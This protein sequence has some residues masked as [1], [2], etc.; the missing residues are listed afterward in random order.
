MMRV[1]TL[2]GLAVLLVAPAARA[3]NVTTEATTSAVLIREAGATI[4]Q[5][6]TVTIGLRRGVAEVDGVS[7]VHPVDALSTPEVT[8][9]VRFA[10]DELEPIA[11]MVRTGDARA[12]YERADEI[13]EI[14]EN[15][16]AAVRR[17][18]LVDAYMLAAV[19]RCQA[20]QRRVC[21]SRIGD[22]VA[23]R[24]SLRYDPERYGPASEEVFDRARARALSGARG[25]L[26]VE[27]EPAG[28]EVYIDGRSYGPSPVTAEGLLAGQH[29]VTVKELGYEKL[30]AR[31]DVRAGRANESTF[32]LEPNAR[33][34]LVISAD[35]QAAIRGEL[36]AER[37]GAAIRSL[38]NTLGTTQVIVGVLRPAAG[39]QV[40][41][42]LYLYHVHTRLLQNQEEATLTVDE[43]GMERARQ[44]AI[45]LYQG[46]DLSGGIEAP[47]D[48][49]AASVQQPELYEEWWFWTAIGGA[50]ALVAGIIIGVAV[51]T[52]SQNVPGGFIRWQGELP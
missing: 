35:A 14:F 9:E 25:T 4:A 33:S 29:Y 22:I 19:G 41:V 28:A 37:A 46:V 24:E 1:L 26:V 36:G 17:S 32:E 49:V 27:T 31:A 21:E 12:A 47:E 40:H 39:D 50:A 43:A 16:L 11:D 34:Q 38:G 48:I 6:S 2:A 51:A 45:D 52:G 42:Q 30:I 8:E 23:F 15:N 44:I 7:F 10:I 13:V 20:G 18:Q 5:A 3:Q